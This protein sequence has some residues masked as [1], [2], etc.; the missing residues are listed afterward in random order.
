MR[1][2]L[3]WLALFLLVY[4][5]LEAV[6]RL[7]YKPITGTSF[8]EPA[9]AAV[10]AVVAED[11]GA[12]RTAR[13]QAGLGFQDPLLSLHPFL[14]YVYTPKSPDQEGLGLP[15]S[16]DG[17]L[18]DQPLIRKRSD[19]KLLV[20]I[21]GG[22]VAGQLGIRFPGPLVEALSALPGV[23]DRRIELVRMGMPGYHQ[24]Q[25]LIQLAWLL[26]QGGELDLLLNIDGFNEIAVPLVLN[27]PKGAHPLFPM[28]WSMVAL[29]TPDQ[30][31]RRYIGAVHHLKRERRE[32]AERFV[33][34]PWSWSPLARLRWKMHDAALER[35][36][37]AYA[38]EL[39]EAATDELP[40]F[41]SGPDWSHDPPGGLTPWLVEVWKSSS[42]QIDAISRLH[43]IRYLHLLQPNQYVEGS[44][45]LSAEERKT[46]YSLESPYRAPV[47]EGYPK[48]LA[49]GKELEAAGVDFHDL[50]QIFEADRRT[51]YVDIC[52]HYNADGNRV[53]AE[54]IASAIGQIE[55]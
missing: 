54:A 29:D 30:E 3:F 27:V 6:A 1:R 34:G 51:F 23:G 53:L 44:K 35:E 36:A 19:D 8:S 38:W 37:A 11:E 46:G 52:C 12:G 5:S 9:L 42:L 2:T 24:P 39:Q 13:E 7:A 10:D 28:N 50:T 22:S 17:F 55:S 26:A 21:V 41:V 32:A 45:P 18:D 40:Y 25:Q 31:R 48:L 43:G 16:A 20:G 33:S 15:I 14:G 47:V 49:A 4:G